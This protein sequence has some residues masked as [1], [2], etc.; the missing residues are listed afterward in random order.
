M[1]DLTLV[2]GIGGMIG[3]HMAERLAREG[4]PVVG[5]SYAPTIDM[6]DLAAGLE[7]IG[8]DIRDQAAVRSVVHRLRPTLRH[9]AG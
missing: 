3:S 8:L 1:S 6:A 4:R 2:V 5:T 7:V 9:T